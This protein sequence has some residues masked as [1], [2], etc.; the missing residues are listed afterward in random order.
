MT[1]G[2]N[3][4]RAPRLHD[5]VMVSS[6]FTDLRELRQILIDAAVA[7]GL[8]PEAMEHDAAR[9]RIVERRGRPWR[10]DRHQARL[11]P[12]EVRIRGRPSHERGT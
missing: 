11:G 1:D 10:L 8:H 6:T 2:D 4:L 3:G 12:Q 5:G 7:A 9:C